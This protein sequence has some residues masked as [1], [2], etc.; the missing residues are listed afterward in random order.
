MQLASSATVS[1]EITLGSSNITKF[2]IPGL[3][4]VHNSTGIGIGSTNQLEFLCQ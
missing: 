1:N 3:N 4:L 2:R